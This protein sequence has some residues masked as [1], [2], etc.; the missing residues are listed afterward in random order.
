M[1]QLLILC[2]RTWELQRLSPLA[3]TTV[4]PES[5]SL[6]YM[7]R[8]AATVRSQHPELERIPSSQQLEQSLCSGED[9]AQ[10]KITN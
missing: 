6:C 5:L 8:E 3:A 7:P 1:P 9:P 10:P 2:S 4:G